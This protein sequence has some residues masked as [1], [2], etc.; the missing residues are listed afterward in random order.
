MA[1]ASL[2]HRLT[3]LETDLRKVSQ[4]AVK[5]ELDLESRLGHEALQQI[6]D[7]HLDIL[8]DIAE[9]YVQGCPPRE[10]DFTAAQ[11]DAMRAF[12]LAYEQAF[13]MASSSQ[14]ANRK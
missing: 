1:I 12:N 6:S 13:Q 2:K 3:R 14:G 9:L 10:E 7:E 4:R 11:R 5:R 8:G